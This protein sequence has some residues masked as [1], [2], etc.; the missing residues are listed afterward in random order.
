M[1]GLYNEI[2]RIDVG[3]QTFAS[4]SIPEEISHRYLGGK[5][6]AT[7]ILLTEKCRSVVSRESPH[8]GNRPFVR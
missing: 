7:H 1:L 6:V 5:G 4:E 8:S 2:L 3:N